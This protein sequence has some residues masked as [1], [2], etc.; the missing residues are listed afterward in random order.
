[1]AY[2]AFLGDESD[3]QPSPDFENFRQVTSPSHREEFAEST[4]A[5][6]FLHDLAES[7]PSSP[8]F[9][10]PLRAEYTL[11]SSPFFS[12]LES[13]DA[14]RAPLNNGYKSKVRVDDRYKVV[15]FISSGTYGRVYKAIGHNGQSGEFAIKKFGSCLFTEE[16]QSLID[17]TQIQAR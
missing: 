15:G 9:V 16:A 6:F 12:S 5:P 3:A 8:S 2:N 4:P 10:S 14:K 11:S 7:V 17:I 1:M 13:P